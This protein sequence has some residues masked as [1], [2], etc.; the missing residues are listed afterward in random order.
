MKFSLK[1]IFFK[2]L[3]ALILIAIVSAGINLYIT[4]YSKKYIVKKANKAPQ[5]YTAL[6]LGAKVY[7]S[8]NLSR[9]LYDRVIKT[10]ELYKSGKVK[11]ILLSGDHGRVNYDEV[12]NMRKFLIKKGVPGRDI[13]MDHAGFNTYDSMVR[14]KKIFRVNKV[15]IITQEFHLPRAVYIARK[16]G[17]EAYGY[18]ADRREYLWMKQYKAREFL[19]RVKSF[20][21]VLINRNPKFLGNQIPITGNSKKS[22]D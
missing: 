22:W 17:M 9:V 12:N 15:I 18:V 19:A 7:R 16:Q 10:L 20:G 11:R 14:A 1:K 13:F 4:S 8:G 5:S 2:T 3:M 6:V 21:E